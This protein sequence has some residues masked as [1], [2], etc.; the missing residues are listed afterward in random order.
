MLDVAMVNML[1]GKDCQPE[2][3]RLKARTVAMPR[4]RLCSDVHSRH[5][6]CRLFQRYVSQ[7]IPAYYTEVGATSASRRLPDNGRTLIG[8]VRA[9]G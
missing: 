4:R 5:P 7:D 2:E 1:K 9:T 8:M 6:T 3:L